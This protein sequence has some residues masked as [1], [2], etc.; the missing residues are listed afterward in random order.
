M[1]EIKTVFLI[2]CYNEEVSIEDVVNSAKAAVPGAE[3]YVCDNNSTDKT[4]QKAAAAGAKVLFE[5]APGKGNAVRRLLSVAEADVYI[6]IDG[7]STY[8]LKDAAAFAREMVEKNID[9]I[10]VARKHTDQ[11]AYRGGHLLGNFILTKTAAL[12][13]GNKINDM[14][15]GYKIFSRK[16]VKTFP[17]FSR[18]FEIETELVIFSLSSRF[19]VVEKS[20]LYYPRPENS[21][22]KLST[23]KDGFKILFTIFNLIREERPLLFFTSVAAAAAAFAIILAIPVFVDYINTGLVAKIPTAVL[24]TGIM[25]WSLMLFTTGL[26]LDTIVKNRKEHRRQLFMNIEKV[27]ED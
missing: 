1:K 7:D 9:F 24:V 18:G 2:P 22:S 13:F 15:S 11:Q 16:F 19:S 6:M 21:P 23:F 26:I 12:F 14:L 17:S 10:N 25:V 20:A 27:K 4:S 5:P 3:I 8:E